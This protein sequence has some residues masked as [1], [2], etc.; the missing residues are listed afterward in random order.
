MALANYLVEVFW[1]IA[2]V[3]SA[4]TPSLSLRVAKNMAEYARA[5]RQLMTK[6]QANLVAMRWFR[7]LLRRRR[8]PTLFLPVQRGPIHGFYHF[9]VG[10]LV[11]VYWKISKHP[12]KKWA[13]MDAS[14]LNHWYQLLPTKNLEIIDQAKT[15]KLA[16]LSRP[17][18]VARGFR[19]VPVIGW[20]KWLLFRKRNL[21]EISVRMRKDLAEKAKSVETRRP[22]IVVLGREYTPPHY[23]EKLPTRYGVAKRNI[24][25]LAEVTQKLENDFDIE[26]VDGATLTPQEM[27]AKC[28][29]AKVLVG[30]HGAA[31]TNLFF[32]APGTSVVEIAWPDLANP[33]HL[34]MYRLLSEELRLNW[35]RAII[36]KH[37]FAEIEAEI[38]RSELT[39]ALAKAGRRTK[40]T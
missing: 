1:P 8:Y 30:Q 13:V 23:A 34:E 7:V 39:R 36:Q 32:M 26:L 9:F 3:K 40:E 4:H 14:P 12:E 25:N 18:G 29:Q 6:K 31:L 33:D 2:A 11:P 37:R 27:F 21:R 38:L 15:V 17:W 22:E 10:Y 16:Y 24:P 5:R 20:D 19:V 28:S 35:S